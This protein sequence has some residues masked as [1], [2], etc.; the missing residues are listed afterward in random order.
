MKEALIE[1][2]YTPEIIQTNNQY[3]RVVLDSC[4]DRDFALKELE[5]YRKGLS[6]TVWILSI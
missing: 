5:K 6:Q 1:K 4:T 3:Y 2:G